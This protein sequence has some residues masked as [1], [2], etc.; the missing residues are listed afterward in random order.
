M[1]LSY[2]SSNEKMPSGKPELEVSASIISKRLSRLLN[3]NCLERS[4]RFARKA[5]S[6]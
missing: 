6:N 3:C 1:E 5:L 4:V 2:V